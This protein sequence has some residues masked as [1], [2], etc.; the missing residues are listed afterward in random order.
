VTRNERWFPLIYDIPADRRTGGDE[1]RA[2][3][4][5]NHTGLS[6]GFRGQGIRRVPG[7]PYSA[8]FRAGFRRHHTQFLAQQGRVPGSGDTLL[9]PGTRYSIFDWFLMVPGT[10]S[11]IF[12]RS[13]PPKFLACRNAPEMSLKPGQK[14]VP[15]ALE[16]PGVVNNCVWCP[17]NLPGTCPEPANP[18]ESSIIVY[19]VPGT[20]PEPAP[21]FVLD[22]GGGRV[23]KPTHGPMRLADPAGVEEH[24]Q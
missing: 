13:I 22:T 3:H 1:R 4:G 15:S 11:S 18:R 2:N 16:S 9:V 7:T 24:G 21:A 17:R 19:G 23:S 5:A 8:G 20:C 6:R 14:L 12:G 10:P